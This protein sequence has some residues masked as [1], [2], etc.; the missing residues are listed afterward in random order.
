MLAPAVMHVMPDCLNNYKQ[1]ESNILHRRGE[2]GQEIV[3]Q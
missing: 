3:I 2:L 1:R